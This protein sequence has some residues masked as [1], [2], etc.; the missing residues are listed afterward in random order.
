MAISP[1]SPPSSLALA[2]FRYQFERNR[3]YGAYCRLRRCSP[4]NATHWSEVPA[5]PTAAFKEAD[6]TTVPPERV[7]VVYV[8]S[9]PEPRTLCQNIPVDPSHV[10]DVYVSQPLAGARLDRA[11]FQLKLDDSGTLDATLRP[12]G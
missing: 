9:D 6:L 7:A 4:E 10:A 12:V 1:L 11:Y 5:L 3:P 2:V 8:T